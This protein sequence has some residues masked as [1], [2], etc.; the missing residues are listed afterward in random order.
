MATE[1][2]KYFFVWKDGHVDSMVTSGEPRVF[3]FRRFRGDR[4]TTPSLVSED[5]PLDNDIVTFEKV[6]VE[7]GLLGYNDWRRETIEYREI[8]QS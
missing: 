4:P 6:Q 2:R 1:T 7:Y 3:R 5:K 8:D